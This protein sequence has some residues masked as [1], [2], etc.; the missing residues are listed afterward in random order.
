MLLHIHNDAN[1][2]KTK[3]DNRLKSHKNKSFLFFNTTVQSH[4]QSNQKTQKFLSF[5]V[6]ITYL[7]WSNGNLQ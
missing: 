2:S 5:S 3:T 6:L 1:N 7:L 4:C